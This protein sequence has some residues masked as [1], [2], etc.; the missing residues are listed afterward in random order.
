MWK[1]SLFLLFTLPLLALAQSDP[2][3]ASGVEGSILISPVTGGPVRQGAADTKP[4]PATEFL[5]KQ[6]DRVVTSFKTD[7]EG[8]FRVSLGPGHYSVVRKERSAVGSY[9]PFEVEVAAGKMSTVQ[10]KCD[11]GLR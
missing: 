8:R 9:G 3:P 5:V 11:T 6:G 10:W 2:A 1:L 4:L 7:A